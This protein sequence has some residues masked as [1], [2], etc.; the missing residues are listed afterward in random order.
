MLRRTALQFS[1][2]PPF[3]FLFLYLYTSSLH[4]FLIIHTFTPSFPFPV[5]SHHCSFTS[6]FSSTVFP[7]RSSY[8]SHHH[9]YPLLPSLHQS[10]IA[11]LLFLPIILFPLFPSRLL[12]HY[13]PFCILTSSSPP[14][15]APSYP[16]HFL[17]IS[18]TSAAMTLQNSH[19]TFN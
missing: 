19:C 9:P 4:F 18:T 3:T 1:G 16:F 17:P 7:S 13:L 10:I 15:T 2:P 5:L 14:L 11:H 12:F 8:P 6:S